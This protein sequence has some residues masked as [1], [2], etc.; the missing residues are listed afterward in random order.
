MTFRPFVLAA[1]AA[2]CLAATGCPAPLSRS[3][4]AQDA[5]QEMNLQARFGRIAVALDRVAPKERDAF[6]R[7]HKAWGSNVRISDHEMAGMRLTG[8]ED[9]EVS[10]REAWFRPD[11]N[12]MRMTTI[13][14]KWHDHKGEW[15][16][17]SEERADGDVGL[18]DDAPLPTNAADPSKGADSG[19]TPTGAPAAPRTRAKTNAQFPTIRIGESDNR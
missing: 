18:L 15:L 19:G 1:C 10:V 3:A 13:R 7:R 14:Q 8:D 9:A 5:A 11:E 17:V 16:L 4:R 6:T 12:E 2:L